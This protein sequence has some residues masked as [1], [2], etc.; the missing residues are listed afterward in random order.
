MCS[1]DL[2]IFTIAGVL[3]VHPETKQA[4]S[5]EQQFVVTSATTPT[6]TGWSFDPPL[7]L[8]GV[9][10]NIDH[11]PSDNDV[12]TFVGTASATEAQHLVFHKETFAFITADLP[13]PSNVEGSRENF[14]GLSIRL[15]KGFDFKSDVEA[16]RLDILYGFKTIRPE[17]ACRMYGS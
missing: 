2:S 5:H 11:L 15:L 10:Q 14:E 12:V 6:T 3:A 9:N 4:Y 8:A 17:W 13:L 1:S 7:Y 16:I